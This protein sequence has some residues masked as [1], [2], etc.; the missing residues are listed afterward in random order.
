MPEAKG[1]EVEEVLVEVPTVVEET[2]ESPDLTSLSKEEIEIGKKH[3]LIKDEDAKSEKSGEDDNAEKAEKPDADKSDDKESEEVEVGDPAT[4]EEMEEVLNKDAEKFHKKFTPNAKALYFKHKKER[5]ER[6]RIAK[7][8]EELKAGSELA[9]VKEGANASKLKKINEALGSEDL[10]IEKLKAIIGEIEEPV[11]DEPKA[12]EDAKVT[13][14]KVYMQRVD[15]ATQIGRSKYKNFDQ[16]SDLVQEMVKEDQDYASIVSTA[17]QGL[18][19]N[20]V[21]EEAVVEKVVKIAKLSPKFKELE[22]NVS[23]DKKEDVN[24]AIKNSNKKLSSAS[25]SGS[26]KSNFKSEDTLTPEDVVNF[27]TSKWMGLSKKTRDRLLQES[28]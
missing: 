10:T 23:S 3:G 16:I 26:G 1:K 25:L 6:Q 20:K 28:S 13:A 22:N 11:K 14:D 17:F 19:N 15:L 2:N 5:Q 4:F 12:K 9:S 8:F 18:Y 27:S 7:E 21:D 24:R